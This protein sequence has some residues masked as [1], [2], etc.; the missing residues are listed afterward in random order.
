MPDK[1]WYEISYLCM[2]EPAP[3]FEGVTGLQHDRILV[4]DVIAINALKTAMRTTTDVIYVQASEIPLHSVC[5]PALP[6]SHDFYRSLARRPPGLE[7]P[8]KESACVSF[9]RISSPLF[10]VQGFQRTQIAFD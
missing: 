8:T 7:P 3:I 1:E 10:M 6:T 2:S 5:G 4:E 9:R